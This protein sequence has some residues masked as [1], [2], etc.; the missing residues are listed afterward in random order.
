MKTFKQIV[1]TEGTHE[2][3]CL[4]I[5][6]K[7]SE[8]FSDYQKKIKKSDLGDDGLEETVHCTLLYGITSDVS[9]D[10]IFKFIQEFNPENIKIKTSKIN[11]FSNKEKGFDV[12]KFEVELTDELQTLRDFVINE[13]PN[14]QTF[15]GY[16]P[17]LTICYTKF[18]LGKK[19]EEEFFPIVFE[20][21]NL[22]YSRPD[23]TKIE[24]KIY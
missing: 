5:N 6:I 4:M 7:E 11:L 22:V 16:S 13:F 15:D 2:Y 18:G 10:E 12:V 17:H 9:E 14:E 19:Y 8:F 23:G 1:E 20:I 24:S 21:K 3:G